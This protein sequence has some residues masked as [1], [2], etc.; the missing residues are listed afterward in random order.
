M[1]KY[2]YHYRDHLGNTRIKFTDLNKS[3]SI[4]AGD[5]ILEESNYYPF[6][7]KHRGYNSIVKPLASSHKYFYNNKEL[8][9][10]HGLEWYD[11]GARF[12]DAALGRWFV[13]DSESEISQAWTPYRY[14]FN[15]PVR[16]WDVGGR[17]EMDSKQAK[18]YQRLSNYIKNDIQAIGNNSRIVNALK[19]YGELTKTQIQ[20][21]LEWNNGP[22]VIIATV[23]GNGKP[24][25]RSIGRYIG[26][27]KLYLNEK[28]VKELETAKGSRR[29][30]LLFRLAQTLLHEYVHYGDAQD[31]I[32]QPGEE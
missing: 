21:D 16:Y 4:E 20:N 32:E 6:G 31:G 2:R 30:A 8:Q 5:E 12:Y 29:E 13:M 14:G 3:G 28:Y 24:M 18:L 19:K 15:N 23:D 11:Y 1:L 22:K 17:F 27:N 10:E 25:G 9:G 7:L 26:G